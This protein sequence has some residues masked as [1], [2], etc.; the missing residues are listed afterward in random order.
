V[1][2]VSIQFHGPGLK[3][4]SRIFDVDQLN[5]VIYVHV[6]ISNMLTSSSSSW[7]GLGVWSSTGSIILTF[8]FFSS[9]KIL[10]SC[11]RKPSFV[12]VKIQ[13]GISIISFNATL[14]SSFLQ[15]ALFVWDYTKG[16][17]RFDSLIHP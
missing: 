7:L 14:I 4:F 10:M 3:K 2:R 8:T 6:Q 9:E 15:I 16:L 5:V 17:Y 1:N 13:F 11:F 12:R